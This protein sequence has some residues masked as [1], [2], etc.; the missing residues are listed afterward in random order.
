STLRWDHASAAELGVEALDREAD[1]LGRVP[2]RVRSADHR[3][4]LGLGRLD[5][6][7]GLDRIADA[8]LDVLEVGAYGAHDFRAADLAMAGHDERRLERLQL[9]QHFDPAGSG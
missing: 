3:L 8:A 1:P 6:A 5:I 7:A 4:E 2:G 9:A